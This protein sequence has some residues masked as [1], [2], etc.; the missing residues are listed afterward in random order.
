MILTHLMRMAEFD[1]LRAVLC[2]SRYHR[3]GGCEEEP[4][5]ISLDPQGTD[6]AIPLRRRAPLVSVDSWPSNP[7]ANGQRLQQAGG[8]ARTQAANQNCPR[9]ER[10][11]FILKQ[12]NVASIT[13]WNRH[14]PWRGRPHRAWVRCAAGLGAAGRR[15]RRC[16][17]AASDGLQLQN[18]PKRGKNSSSSSSSSSEESKLGYAEKQSDG[19]LQSMLKQDA[20]TSPLDVCV[21]EKIKNTKYKQN[22]NGETCKEYGAPHSPGTVGR[23]GSG[24]RACA[25]SFAGISRHDE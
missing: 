3:V 9:P 2:V 22:W 19:F 4:T 25:A 6:P 8:Q 16:R 18:P 12:R 15:G 14:A 21:Y 23:C 1:A 10:A 17:P 5:Q 13:S 20:R 7:K 24:S 11:P